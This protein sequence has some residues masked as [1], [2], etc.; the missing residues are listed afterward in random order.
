MPIDYELLI[1]RPYRAGQIVS[2]DD[3]KIWSYINGYDGTVPFGLGM[4]KGE[5]PVGIAIKLPSKIHAT[6]T[7]TLPDGAFEAKDFEG[8]SYY[9]NTYEQRAGYSQDAAGRPGYP[10]K[11][12]ISLVRAGSI[13]AVWLDSAVKRGDPVFVRHTGGGGGI[14]GC[15]R[16]E[17]GTSAVATEIKARFCVTTPAPATGQM[18]VG[19]IEFEE[20]A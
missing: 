14:V 3:A 9:T 15:F 4:V 10:V 5:D 19:F 16:T 13:V 17:S 18:T 20:M 1:D 11:Q 12:V 7:V 6:G 2:L 8:V